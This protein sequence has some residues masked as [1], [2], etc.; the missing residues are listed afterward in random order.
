[1]TLGYACINTELR[2]QKPSV[3]INRGMTKKTFEAKGLAYA[4]SLALANCL[5]LEQII[6][7]NEQN[8][9]KLFRISGD[10][11]P[12]GSEYRPQDLPDWQEIQEALECA[13]ELATGFKQRLTM[14]PGPFVVLTSP[15][16]VVV[17]ASIRELELHGQILDLLKQPRTPWAKINIHCN[18]VYGDKDSAQE[19]FIQNFKR[20]SDSVK[21]RLTVENDDKASMYSVSDLMRIHKET[22]IPIVFDYHHHKFNQGD[23]SEEEALLLAAS[24][25]GDI[26]PV[27]HYSESRRDHL[28][29]PKIKPQAHSDLIDRLP[30]LYGQNVHVMVEAKSKEQAILKFL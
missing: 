29:D 21:S 14:H 16:D 3:T 28:S 22:S 6:R 15:R 2:A 1:M 11:F 10:L 23:L 27:V 8:S 19:R 17:Q 26:C 30:N 24:T 25:W 20:L 5:D 12:W 9:I 13:G 18:G 4:S 7:W